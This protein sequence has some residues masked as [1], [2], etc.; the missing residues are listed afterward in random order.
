MLDMLDILNNFFE[1]KSFFSDWLSGII[2][3]LFA[4]IVL[5][6]P[7]AIRRF[8][9]NKKYPIKGDF[10]T[11][12]EDISGGQKCTLS[13]PATISQKGLDIKGK[14]TLELGKTWILEGKISDGNVYGVYYAESPFDT[15]IGNFFLEINAT[16]DLDGIWSGYDHVNKLINSGRYLFKRTPK[17]QIQSMTD[18]YRT[19]VLQLSSRLLGKGYLPTISQSDKNKIVSLVAISSKK[20]IGFAHAKITEKD[21]LNVILKNPQIDIPPDLKLADETGTLGFLKT[22]CVEPDFQGRGVATILIKECLN[23]LVTLGAE[24]LICIAWKNSAG[25]QIGGVLSKLGFREWITLDKFWAEESI[26]Q[27][28]SC[29]VCG[30]PPCNCS[31]VIYNCSDFSKERKK[32]FK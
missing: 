12:Y 7:K 13:A 19:N 20:L 15:G 24:T 16:G 21:D 23:N 22:V 1:F 31:A 3:A 10:I 6:I 5:I 4:G 8:Y 9:L 2:G 17:I 28:F 27:N 25:V 11:Y 18:D 14:T 26:S 32:P 30:N 29:P